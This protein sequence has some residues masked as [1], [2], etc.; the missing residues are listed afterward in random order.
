MTMEHISGRACVCEEEQA[1]FFTPSSEGVSLPAEDSPA[2]AA[3]PS[4]DRPAGADAF[5]A[6][7]DEFSAN[8]RGLRRL[9]Q[10]AR[11]E[12][13]SRRFLGLPY[14]LDPLGEGSGAEID[15]DP[16]SRGDGADCM[17]MVEQAMALALAD[18]RE[19]FEDTLACIRYRDCVPLYGMRNHHVE[20][21]VEQNA[22]RGFVRDITAQV[23]GKLAASATVT[24]DFMGWINGKMDLLPAQKMEIADERRRRGIDGTRR[25]SFDFI[26]LSALLFAGAESA[27][28][29]PAVA[30][31]LPEI[32]IILMIG[33]E[34]DEIKY[35]TR[36]RHMG[37][38][39]VPRL[40][41]GKRGEPILRHCTPKD[42]CVD[43]PLANYI[44]SQ[45][46]YRAGSVFLE[47]TGD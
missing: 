12:C 22:K 35:G 23:G 3:R 7:D 16:M 21:W 4:C 1:V 29:S 46:P 34:E 10:G 15:S 14:L 43:R 36:V 5:A 41:G 28:I 20:D 24:I 33:K 17:T 32:S 30:E 2:E 40:E 37:F 31:K 6:D 44:L 25:H 38:V 9:L 13:A 39:I 19:S 47:I 11:T 26:P 45:I 42:G 8:L 18:S 27:T